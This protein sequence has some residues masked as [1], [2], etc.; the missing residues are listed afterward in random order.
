METRQLKA[1][2]G[3]NKK[4]RIIG[5]GTGT[6]K[7]GTAGR[8]H[9]GQNSRS[10]G[11]V[12]PGFE[13]G[14]MPLYRRL[15]RR[16][17]SNY[18]FKKEYTIINLVDLEKKFTEG[19]TVNTASLKEKGL[20]KKVRLPVKILGKGEITKK[21]TVEVAKISGGAR[22]KIEKA[23]GTVSASE[24]KKEEQQEAKP[25]KAKSEKA[26]KVEEKESENSDTME[27]K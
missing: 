14:Q 21:L 27:K 1:P 11:G 3:A 12:R 17:F 24:M 2:K 5:R 7:G 4:K 25:K 16:G 9:K 19:E 8:G 20:L 18:P 10:G 15:A 6:G 22:E 26:E 13:G 23:G